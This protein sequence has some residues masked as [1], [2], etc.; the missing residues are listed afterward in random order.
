MIDLSSAMAKTKASAKKGKETKKVPKE[1]ETKVPAVPP[2]RVRC[3][4][5]DPNYRTK[6]PDPKKLKKA[7][8]TMKTGLLKVATPQNQT[9]RRKLSFNETPSIT[10]IEA[11]NPV[12]KR[13]AKPSSSKMT[14]AEAD[15]ILKKVANDKVRCYQ[16]MFACLYFLSIS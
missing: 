7:E 4:T 11:E 3:K 14:G 9:I 2:L 15:K 6:S 8:K 16:C 5:P 1:K 13:S 10:D 12:P